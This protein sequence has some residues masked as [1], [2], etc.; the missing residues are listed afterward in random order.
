M[1]RTYDREF[2]KSIAAMLLSNAAHAVALGDLRAIGEIALSDGMVVAGAAV[3]A[4]RRNAWIIR[5]E[6]CP[7]TWSSGA[8]DLV[9]SRVTNRDR[10]IW[11]NAVE[12]KWWRDARSA[13]ASNRRR[14]LLKDMIR[15]AAIYPDVEGSALVALL[16]TRSAW[17]ATVNTSG[18]DKEICSRFTIDGL[19]RWNLSTLGDTPAVKGA[20]SSL[21]G[22]PRIPNILHT[23]LLVTMRI[24]ETSD[25]AFA[26]VWGVRKPEKSRWI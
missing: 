18:A 4:T 1:A 26:R 15:A 10:E 16:T 8:I 9:V 12:L 24:G 14:D 21:T 25:L 22:L 20:L 2:A 7:S 3:G 13:N 5:R 11:V 6:V 19:A 17:K 23:K